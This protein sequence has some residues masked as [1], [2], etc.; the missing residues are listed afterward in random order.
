M[1]IFLR[2]KLPAPPPGPGGQGWG[3]SFELQPLVC[4]VFSGKVTTLTQQCITKEIKVTANSQ[5]DP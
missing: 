3:T 4:T 1:K 5:Q 2:I